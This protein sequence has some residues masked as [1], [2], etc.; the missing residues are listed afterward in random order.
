MAKHKSVLMEVSEDC[1]RLSLMDGSEWEVSPGDMSTACTWIP[2]AEIIVKPIHTGSGYDH[3]LTNMTVR[4]S[5]KA[6]RV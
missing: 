5:V 1:E 2:T 3:E 6:R 4:V